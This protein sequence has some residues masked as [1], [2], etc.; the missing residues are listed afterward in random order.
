MTDV[1][2]S[3]QEVA[4]RVKRCDDIVRERMRETPPHIAQPWVN[5]ASDKRPEWRFTNAAAVDAWWEELHRW[6][7]S[8]SAAASGKSDGASPAASAASPSPG[9]ATRTRFSRPSR[10]AKSSAPATSALPSASFTFLRSVK[11]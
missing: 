9:S 11:P 8:E 6:R 3:V 7:A 1:W 4:R 5:V 10:D 2:L